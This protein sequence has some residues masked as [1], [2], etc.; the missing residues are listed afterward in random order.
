MANGALRRALRDCSPIVEGEPLQPVELPPWGRCWG[1]AAPAP[2]SEQIGDAL[3]KEIYAKVE[4]N[5]AGSGQGATGAARGD[6][7]AGGAAP[8]PA[9]PP[10]DA[11]TYLAAFESV[12]REGEAAR[13]AAPS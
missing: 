10:G 5:Q 3:L 2:P 7:G 8:P 6:K 4:R 13:G 12:V 1:A 11:S 9:A